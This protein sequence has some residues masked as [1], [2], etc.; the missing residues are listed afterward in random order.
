MRGVMR[1][2]MSQKLYRKNS[3]DC[4]KKTKCSEGEQRAGAGVP[5]PA[6]AGGMGQ[7]AAAGGQLA[8]AAA[9]RP[10]IGRRAAAA[11]AAVHAVYPPPPLTNSGACR[12]GLPLLHFSLQPEPFSSLHH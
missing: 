10:D 4:E 7:R 8:A 12:Q 1:G 9:P 5:L 2:M 11:A 6:D 3:K